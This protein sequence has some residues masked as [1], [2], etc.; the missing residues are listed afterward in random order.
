MFCW[1]REI[2]F[3]NRETSVIKSADFQVRSL[4]RI[5]FSSITLSREFS[6]DGEQ[7]YNK[8][9]DIRWGTFKRIFLL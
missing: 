7:A 2:N 6:F 9:K 8:E 3:L 4:I 1:K 5:D